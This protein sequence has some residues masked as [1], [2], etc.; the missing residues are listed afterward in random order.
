MGSGGVTVQSG[1]LGGGKVRQ[2][3]LSEISAIGD[4]ITAQQGGATGTP[5][6]NIELTLRDGKKVTLG[7]TLRDQHEAAWLVEEMQRLAGLQTKGVAA[8]LV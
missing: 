5:Y 1:L 6:Y 7:S 8:G 4:R 2:I 3:A